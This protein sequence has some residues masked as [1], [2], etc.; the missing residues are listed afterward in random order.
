MAMAERMLGLNQE[1]F[2]R[3]S[4]YRRWYNWMTPGKKKD[5]TELLKFPNKEA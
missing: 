1:K 3:L 2:G 5:S 4:K